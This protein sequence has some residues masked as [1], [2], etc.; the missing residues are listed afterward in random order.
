MRCARPTGPGQRAA[1]P[2]MAR[3]R[4]RV[5]V[6]PTL[7]DVL[8]LAPGTWDALATIATAIG[9]A[10]AGVGA[11]IAARQYKSGER[12]RRD[13]TRPQVVVSIQ[14]SEADESFM[15]L[16]IENA[17]TTPAHDERVKITPPLEVTR[18]HELE[19][20]YRVVIARILNERGPRT[21]KASDPHADPHQRRLFRVDRDCSRRFNAHPRDQDTQIMG[22]AGQRCLLPAG[23]GEGSRP[24]DTQAAYLLRRPDVPPRRLAQP[25]AERPRPLRHQEHRTKDNGSALWPPS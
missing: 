25:R 15:N 11:V 20:Q 23:L 18:Q 1:P 7:S 21:S 2:G 17:G 4:R 24:G 12:A 10:L 19:E 16:V 8:G 5:L 9:V 3:V 13:R 6:T 22:T 14:P